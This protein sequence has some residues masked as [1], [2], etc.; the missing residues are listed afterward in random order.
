MAKI[1]FI[2]PVKSVSGKLSKASTVT[3]MRRQAATSNVAML[4]NPNYTHIMG[5]RT[6]AVSQSEVAYRTRF[7]AICTATKARLHDSTKMAADLAAF[8]K[9]SV[10]KTLRQYVW[11]QCAEEV[12]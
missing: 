7:G 6:T 4:A 9:Q 3:F 8:K 2:D 12:A 10:Y 5:K 1:T 11:H